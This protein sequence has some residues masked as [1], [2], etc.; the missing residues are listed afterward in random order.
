MP[1]TD[2]PQWLDKVKVNTV[3]VLKLE[4]GE[5]ITAEILQ[6]ND[7]GELIVD[8]VTSNPD[9]NSGQ[10]RRAISISRIVS[11]E[12]QPRADQPWPYC[13]PCREIS[14]SLGRFVVLMTLV[15]CLIPGSV[16][17]FILLMGRPYGLQ[18]ASVIVYTI[19]EIFYTF[20]A[21]RGL[22]PYMF[23]CPA[24]R[25]Q[26]PRLLWRHLGFLVALVALQTAALAVR[27]NLPAWW[28]TKS[29]QGRHSGP[30]F[31]ITLLFLC[32]GLGFTQVVTNRF[33]LDRAHRER[34]AGG[35]SV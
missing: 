3:A 14:F 30:P 11:Y 2:L 15:L 26:V 13:D 9:P 29:G 35:A 16:L 33:L 18:E 32:G 24:V 28:N 34:Q 7:C 1:E 8:V 10:R 25:P 19:S 17:L 20:A 6:F 4:D 21:T 31:E 23:T 12:P 22:R 27:P 5:C